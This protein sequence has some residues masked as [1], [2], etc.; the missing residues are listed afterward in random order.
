MLLRRGNRAPPVPEH[1]ALKMAR[2]KDLWLIL[3]EGLAQYTD[4]AGL[5]LGATRTDL[6]FGRPQRGTLVLGPS[7]S[8]KTT[9]IVVPQVLC[10]PGPVVTTSTKLDVFNATAMA[11]ACRGNVWIFDPTGK[12]EIPPGARRP[13]WSPVTGAEDWDTAVEAASI[14]VET[15]RGASGS[16]HEA[17]WNARAAG[18]LGVLVHL[19]ARMNRSMRQVLYWIAMRDSEYLLRKLHELGAVPEEDIAVAELC[20]SDEIP[21][22]EDWSLAFEEM[23]GVAQTADN[24]ASGIWGTTKSTLSA[25]GSRSALESCESQNFDPDD[26]VRS[27]DAIYITAP[28]E[29]QRLTA[30]LVV[31]LIDAI[32]RAAYKQARTQGMPR[33]LTLVLDEAANIAPLPTLPQLVSEGGG[34]GVLTSAFFQDLSQA[35]KRWGDEA[36]GF[37][38][39][40]G[41]RL[42]LPGIINK[43]TNEL[44]RMVVG[45]YDRPMVSHSI[46]EGGGKMGPS[47]TT[48]WSKHREALLPESRVY[49]GP[50]PGS[51]W[52]LREQDYMPAAPLYLTPY[53]ENPPWPSMLVSAM[54]AYEGRPLPI[55]RLKVVLMRDAKGREWEEIGYDAEL[56]RR[57]REAMERQRMLSAR[58]L[59]APPSPGDGRQLASGEK[60]DRTPDSP[61]RVEDNETASGALPSTKEPAKPKKETASASASQE[62]PPL[63]PSQPEDETEEEAVRVAERRKRAAARQMRQQTSPALRRALPSIPR[64]K[65][66]GN[67]KAIS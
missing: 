64:R 25:Y 58:A 57:Y 35:K 1:I 4:V 54:E 8:G 7:R 49:Q 10:A 6:S 36:L 21:P 40:F 24:E 32:R 41:E 62:A 17:Y 61:T 39:L 29:K 9:S 63:P 65:E 12:E 48:S 26:F 15:T 59:L 18:L 16:Q 37:L 30:P 50:G 34:M 60:G 31:G 5:F 56:A 45:D 2:E 47:N 3:P 67:G 53:Y 11:R 66:K 22:L 23:A 28:A 46:S 55:P 20:A 43:E 13:R 27:T 38:S 52:H 42:F 44:V 33:P 14:M 19:A 51:M